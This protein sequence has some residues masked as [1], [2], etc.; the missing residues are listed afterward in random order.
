MIDR[1]CGMH[2]RKEKFTG[3]DHKIPKKDTTW[4]IYVNL[5][6]I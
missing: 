4:D 1:M 3:F 5:L 2:G 6:I